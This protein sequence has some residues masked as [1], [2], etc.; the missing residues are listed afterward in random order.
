MPNQE[1]IEQKGGT[2]RLG[3]YTAELK[4]Q[5]KEIYGSEQASER[6]RH[7]YEVNPEYH[8]ELEENGLKISGKTKNGDLTEYIEIEDHP[9]F[10]GT[11]AHPEFNSTFQKPNPLYHKFI[12]TLK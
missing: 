7:R 6:H 8:K 10:I 12:K 1:N 4:G 5:V 2:M 11:Q 3:T 9:F